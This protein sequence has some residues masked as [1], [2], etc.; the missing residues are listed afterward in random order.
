[1]LLHPFL[2][3]HYSAENLNPLFTV[4]TF[5]DIMFC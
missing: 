5:L 2:I 4:D 3:S 1:M